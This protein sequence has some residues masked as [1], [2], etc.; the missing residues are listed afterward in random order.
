MLEP[1]IQYSIISPMPAYNKANTAPPAAKTALP[2]FTALV[3]A[4]PATSFEAILFSGA[5]ELP[6]KV[7]ITC[8]TQIGAGPDIFGGLACLMV[9]SGLAPLFSTELQ[10]SVWA[11]Y[12]Q[13]VLGFDQNIWG[14]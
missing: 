7:M 3:G 5:D 4:R 6:E 8:A 2:T 13:R 9:Y 10:L 14:G 1:A 11:A 12:L